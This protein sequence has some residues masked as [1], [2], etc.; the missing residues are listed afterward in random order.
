MIVIFAFPFYWMLISSVKTYYETIQFPPTLWP[1]SFEWENFVTVWESGPYLMYTKNSIVITF[2]ILVLQSFVM[3]PASYAFAV[4]D[5]K[6]K[7]S[8][9]ALVLLAFMIPTQITF[10]TTYIMFADWNLLKTLWPQILP[11][12]ANAFGIFML[13]QAFMQLPTEILDSARIDNAKEYQI[14]FRIFLPMCKPVFIAIT[15]FSF[16]SHWNSY[17]WPLVMT[18]SD[19]VRPLTIAIAGLRDIETGSPWHL[20]MAGNVILVLPIIIIYI[21]FNKQI[22]NAFVYTGIK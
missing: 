18:N 4:Y 19:I 5:F 15:M 20:I 13:R 22:I 14:A 8:L 17:F 10:I 12:G 9:F 6:F 7:N 3:I 16:I 2:S 21:L 1:K 11:F